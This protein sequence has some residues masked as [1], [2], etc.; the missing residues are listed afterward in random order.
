MKKVFPFFLFCVLCVIIQ[1]GYLYVRGDFRP[2]KIIQK[3][4]TEVLTPE[5]SQ[6]IQDLLE[7]KFIYLNRGHDFYAFASEDGQYVLKIP[8]YKFYPSF[9][10]KLFYFTKK[11]IKIRKHRREILTSRFEI[12]KEHF[13][14]TNY[15]L[16][17]NK[18]L[19]KIDNIIN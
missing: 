14:R 6:N 4:D 15:K 7:Q 8:R 2:G 16:G 17:L 1:Q 13:L 19:N 10:H 5:C 3:L 11:K 12:V 9:W 18:C